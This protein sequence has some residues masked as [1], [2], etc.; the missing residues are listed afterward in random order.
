MMLFAML[1]VMLAVLLTK[2]SA[3]AAM[4]VIPRI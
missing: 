4:L 1:V 3:V 2:N